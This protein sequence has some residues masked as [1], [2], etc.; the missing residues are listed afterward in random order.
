VCP[1]VSRDNTIRVGRLADHDAKAL[2]PTEK[3]TLRYEP[4]VYLAHPRTRYARDRATEV[5]LAEHHRTGV[6][7]QSVGQC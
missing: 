6:L 7:S 1:S 5:S 3:L 4:L 2:G